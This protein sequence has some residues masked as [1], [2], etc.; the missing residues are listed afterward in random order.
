MNFGEQFSMSKKA[1][2]REIGERIQNQFVGIRFF[3]FLMPMLFPQ[4]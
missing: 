4:L 2:K 3:L 1:L